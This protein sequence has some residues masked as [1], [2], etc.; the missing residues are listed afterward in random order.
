MVKLFLAITIFFLFGFLPIQAKAQSSPSDEETC[1]LIIIGFVGGMRSPNDRQ[2]GVVQIGNR[3]RNL[4]QPAL[5][6]KIYRHWFWRSAYNF[7]YQN[8]D[9][10]HDKKLSQEE[11]ALAP[12][13][14]VYGHSLGG[15]AVIKLTRKL[16]KIGV[17]VELTVQI[18]TVGIGDEVVPA[19]VKSAANFYQRNVWLLRG[20]KK[21]RSADEQ[22][23]TIVGNFLIQ[24]TGHEALAREAQIADFITA[25]VRSLCVAPVPLQASSAYRQ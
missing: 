21:I 23:T 22:K 2:Q 20:E 4:N 8:L 3:L 11:L 7:I 24:H 14:V 13:I 25:K 16:E 5:Q 12:K 18:D 15:W 17:P 1:P 10:N 6:V 9:R 19:N